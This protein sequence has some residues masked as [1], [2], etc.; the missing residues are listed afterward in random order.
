V[1]CLQVKWEVRVRGTQAEC[2]YGGTILVAFFKRSKPPPKLGQL[3]APWVGQ[4]SRWN[5]TRGDARSIGSGMLAAGCTPSGSR[6]PLGNGGCM[7]EG[8][9]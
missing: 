1:Q 5:R 2:Q 7:L 4:L 8:P 3:V 6:S 9:R